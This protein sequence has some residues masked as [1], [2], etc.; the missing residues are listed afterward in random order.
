MGWSNGWPIEVVNVESRS[1]S[2]GLVRWV[3]T[4]AVVVLL[5]LHLRHMLTF[6]QSRRTLA[7]RT[8]QEHSHGA[9]TPPSSQSHAH[10]SLQQCA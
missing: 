9:L 3:V 2:N 10:I 4:A 7:T 8:R 6:T 1:G 5:L